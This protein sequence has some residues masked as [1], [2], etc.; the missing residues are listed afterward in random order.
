[1]HSISKKCEVEQ[2][3]WVPTDQNPAD[4]LTRGTAKLR[5]IGTGSFHQK[6]PN[7]LS[8]PRDRW[9]VTRDFVPEEIPDNEMR[10]K[11]VAFSGAVRAGV[12][13]AGIVTEVI[14]N[15]T[16]YSNSMIKV[17]RILARVI[18]GWGIRDWGLEITNPKALTKIAAE[19][20]TEELK[21]AR[22]VLLAHGMIATSQAL[23]EGRLASLLPVWQGMLVVTCGRLG[24]KNMNRLLGVSN[25]PILMPGSRVAYLYMAMAHEGESGLSNTAVEHHRD[26]V[27][28]L[29]RSRS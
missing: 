23:E 28:T 18:R 25:L 26:A 11:P 15:L 9:P 17:Q 7:F 6:G 10:H 20:T 16:H 22:K 24:E 29:A 3:H 4:L 5:D 8:S 14:E 1:M 21:R 2:V 13:G 19:P 27:G 12:E